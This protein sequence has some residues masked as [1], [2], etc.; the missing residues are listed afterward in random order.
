M[1]SGLTGPACSKHSCTCMHG[2]ADIAAPQPQHLNRKVWPVALGRSILAGGL[3]SRITKDVSGTPEL[4]HWLPW[5]HLPLHFT[6]GLLFQPPCVLL[7]QMVMR[8]YSAPVLPLLLL[9]AFKVASGAAQPMAFKLNEVTMQQFGLL[10]RSQLPATGAESTGA[11]K[12][13]EVAPR[14]V[15]AACLG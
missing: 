3:Y 9:L 5:I 8:Q 1:S 6:L 11:R 13:K 10:E 4:P 15:R 12:L 2:P 14:A 7:L